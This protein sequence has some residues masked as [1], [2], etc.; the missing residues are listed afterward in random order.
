MP[1]VVHSQ[2]EEDGNNDWNKQNNNASSNIWD[3]GGMCGDF[4]GFDLADIAAAALKFRNDTQS[5]S[6]S[7]HKLEL[8]Q[9]DTNEP[10]EGVPE[11]AQDDFSSSPL[12]H[13]EI[14]SVSK[15]DV[16]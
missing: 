5:L 12:K 7:A 14:P 3:D 6:E 8:Q 2:D 13:I 4:G 16:C 11:W 9:D 15:S 10:D 1:S